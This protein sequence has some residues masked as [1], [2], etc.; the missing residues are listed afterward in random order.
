MLYILIIINYKIN[1]VL[2]TR[3][4][5]YES[6][7]KQIVYFVHE[8]H[9]K[10][11]PIPLICRSKKGIDGIRRNSFL[12][13][14]CS[15]QGNMTRDFSFLTPSNMVTV[16]ESFRISNE[17]TLHARSITETTGKTKR[18]SEDG[19]GQSVGIR[20]SAFLPLA[21]LQEEERLTCL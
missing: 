15:S 11:I 21:L 14:L 20:L 2:Y 8:L 9:F 13:Q 6:N 17:N 12:L 3:A 4:R 5:I 7:N 16:H 19:D 18:T 1:N 10:I